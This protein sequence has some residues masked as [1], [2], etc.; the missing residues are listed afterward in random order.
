[1]LTAPALATWVARFGL[2]DSG[3][4]PFHAAFDQPLFEHLLFLT[5]LQRLSGFLMSAVDVGALPV[6]GDQR[7]AVQEQHLK[8]C[9][10]ALMLE[11]QLLSVAEDLW[12][13]GIE[14]LVLKG[15]ANAH[16]AYTDP[17][18]RTFGDNDVL[19]RSEDFEL[20]LQVLYDH[21]YV[22]PAAPPGPGFD[23]RFGKG[24]TLRRPGQ[25]ELDLHRTLVFGSFG[26]LID[27]E[28]LFSSSVPFRIGG[29]ELRA[30]G[31]ETR[32]LHACY[33][34]ALGDPVPRLS[35]VRDVAQILSSDDLDARR[36]LELS[37]EWGSHAVL[38]RAFSLTERVLGYRP[39]SPLPE[40]VARYQPTRRER[41]AIASY[42]GPNRH[43]A[44]KVIAS[45]PYLDSTRDRLAF[46]RA[47]LAP[48]ES[49]SESRGAE[50]G[51]AW[52]VRGIRSL[53]PGG[54][55]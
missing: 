48:S 28:E 52:V 54:I 23:R 43:Y 5:D 42:V 41:R 25:D 2:P 15:T 39:N 1:M 31:T 53:L 11:G 40:I 50:S 19:I 10:L 18:V 55:R 16:L 35:S 51:F 12:R 45:L 27:P 26:F 8:W 17:A 29:R 37:R 9:A 6:S 14:F 38:A 4:Q 7:V 47:S 44:A 34:A 13:A 3:D 24:A 32:L 30:L 36:V 33:H 21:G 22:R 20:A 46:V 49:F